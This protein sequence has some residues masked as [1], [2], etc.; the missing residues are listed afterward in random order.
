MPVCVCVGVGDTGL[1]VVVI[2]IDIL[3]DNERETD[4]LTL[5]DRVTE[6]VRENDLLN[7]AVCDIVLLCDPERDGERVADLV[8]DILG[9]SLRAALLVLL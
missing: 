8:C 4:A 2:E 9:V 1:R 5:S 7:D 6:F 3:G